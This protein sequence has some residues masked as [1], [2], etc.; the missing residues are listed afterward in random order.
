MARGKRS[1]SKS[2]CRDLSVVAGAAKGT[3]TESPPRKRM[4]VFANSPGSRPV[5]VTD[6]SVSSLT[7]LSPASTRA[8]LIQEA[9]SQYLDRLR[10]LRRD[11]QLMAQ[12]FLFQRD[13][14]ISFYNRNFTKRESTAKTA[15][16]TVETPEDVSFDLE[17]EPHAGSSFADL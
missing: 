11:C 1:Y 16:V 17:V 13:E 15:H 4:S 12:H 6:S 10:E 9:H 3:L 7:S 5:T 14:K 2:T 8:S